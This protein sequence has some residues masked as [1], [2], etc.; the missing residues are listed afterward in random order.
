M[1][2]KG[3]YRTKFFL[4]PAGTLLFLIITF[5]FWGQIFLPR[6][7]FTE[8]YSTVVYDKNRRLL[9]AHIAK[10]GQWRFPPPDSLPQKYTTALIAFEDR[11][12]FSHPG[13]NPVSLFHA[14]WQDINS[15]KIKRGGSTITMQVIRM[16]RRHRKRTVGEKIIEIFLATALEQRYSKREI[17]RLYAAYAP[18]G[19]NVVGIEAACWRYFGHSLRQL[20]WAEA[21]TLAVLP[22]A[23]SLIHP[24]KNR[25]RLLEKRNKLLKKLYEGGKTDS[26]GYRLALL[27]KIP[28]KPKPLPNTAP[29]LTGYFSSVRNGE[30][31]VTTLDKTIQNRAN[32]IVENYSRKYRNNEIKNMALL[33]IRNSD[34]SVAAYVGN[35]P[36]RDG[37]GESIDMIRADRSTGSIL[38]PLLYAAAIEDGETLINSLIPDIPSYFKNYHPQNYDLTFEGA[39]PAAEALSR[40][41]NVPA[42][43]LLRD[44]G[45]AHFLN[46]LHRTGITGFKKPAGYYGLSMI[47]GGGEASLWDIS[48]MYSGMAQT[49]LNYSRFYGKYTGNEYKHPVLIQDELKPPSE[50]EYSHDV[51]IHAGAVWVTWKALRKVH[52]PQ[53]EEGWEYFNGNSNIAWK[54]GT[55]FGF[56]D[57]WAIGTTADFTVGVWTGN[58]DGEGR[59]G[60]T[61]VS[62]AAPVMFDM[63]DKLPSNE[64]FEAPEDELTPV[65][66]CKKSGYRASEICPETDTILT[67]IKGNGVKLCSYHKKIFTDKSGKFRV[68]RGCTSADDIEPRLWFVLPPVQEWYYRKTHPGY[69]PLPPY[70]NGCLQ[71]ENHVMEFVYPHNGEKILVTRGSD[72]KKQP[73]V[74]ELTHHHPQQKIYWHIDKQYIGITETVHQLAFVPEQGKHSLTVV[75]EKG[76]SLTVHFEVLEN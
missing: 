46:L 70:R 18:F 45:T 56:K 14:A 8:P 50:P 59:F 16:M 33:V 63:F 2:I 32:G 68:H 20:T 35:S 28:G 66:V 67:W 53:E 57:A 7:I 24:G 37:N 5:P 4:I 19:G 17:V 39:I 22:N 34:K 23:P 26:T 51:P 21:A 76:N 60:L 48:S 6:H 41:R 29:H 61:G 42:I 43:Y 3:F 69:K 64:K 74:F 65:V 36:L 27:E 47:L 52:R 55:S 13:F 1:K 11:Y 54:T 71:N 12:F 75:D 25:A 62:S 38:K 44:Y 10:D 9:G 73:V 40:S 49:L 72:G 15:G 58:A 31:I 30:I